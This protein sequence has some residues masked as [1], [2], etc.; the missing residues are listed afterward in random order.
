MGLNELIEMQMIILLSGV[1]RKTRG[2]D[3]VE[4]KR[5]RNVA[6]AQVH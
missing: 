4:S 2:I 3:P 6:V 5:Q 1:T